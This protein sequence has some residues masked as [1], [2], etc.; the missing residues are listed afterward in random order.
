MCV[1]T[2]KRPEPDL[3]GRFAFI[4][5]TGCNGPIRAA[6]DLIPGTRRALAGAQPRV[7]LAILRGP[8]VLHHIKLR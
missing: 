8:I 5:G 1:Y 3:C 2:R 4:N 6:S 7:S